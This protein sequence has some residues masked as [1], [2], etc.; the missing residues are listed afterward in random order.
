MSKALDLFKLA[1]KFQKLAENPPPDED[2]TVP[3]RPKPGELSPSL[4]NFY[5]EFEHL[6]AG[7]SKV[8]FHNWLRKNQ[9]INAG[10]TTLMYLVSSYNWWYNHKHGGGHLEA[11]LNYHED[12]D[13]RIYLA[14]QKFAD[15]AQELIVPAAEGVPQLWLYIGHFKDE[16]KPVFDKELA[17]NAYIWTA[18]SKM[19]ELKPSPQEINQVE[20]FVHVNKNKINK[21]R[22]FFTQQPRFLGKGADGAA[23]DIGNFVLKIFLDHSAAEAAMEAIERLHTQPSISKT[24]AMIHDVGV[25]GQFGH[26]TLYYYVMEKMQPIAEDPVLRESL[27]D[28]IKEIVVRLFSGTDIKVFKKD[29]AKTDKVEAGK[30]VV[31]WANSIAGSLSNDDKVKS[32]EFKFDGLKKTWLS[33]LVEEIAMKYLTDRTDLHIGNLGLSDHGPFGKEFRYFDPAY[34]RFTS[35][36]NIGGEHII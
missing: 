27:R 9:A 11:K 12:L 19:F 3:N 7:V 13:A 14:P 36:V 32:V 26:Y 5:D 17:H 28:L 15:I 35:T 33:S 6:V 24:E 30:K 31:A 25:L 20:D 4:K 29:F 2:T 8:E 23:F 34:R 22:K 18:F 21:I 16:A 10:K 1:L